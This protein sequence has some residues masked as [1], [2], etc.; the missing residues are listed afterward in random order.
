[1]SDIVVGSLLPECHFSRY[2]QNPDLPTQTHFFHHLVVKTNAETSRKRRRTSRP[3]LN[4][5]DP[6]Q[7]QVWNA[8]DVELDLCGTYSSD[9]DFE[10]EEDEEPSPKK[11]CS[12]ICPPAPHNTTSELIDDLERRT[13]EVGKHHFSEAI[14]ID[15]C[16][17]TFTEST[18]DMEGSFL[19]SE[20]YVSESYE[21]C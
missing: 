10:V 21:S 20:S 8:L 14:D 4:E 13:I 2:P 12:D 9:S 3:C 18:W 11:I 16:I 19:V 1:M 7:Q 17:E 6:L 15:V 5:E